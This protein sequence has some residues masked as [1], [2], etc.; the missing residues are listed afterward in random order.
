MGCDIH[1]F[2]EFQENDSGQF[3]SVTEDELFI[4][5]DY[6]LFSAIA[7]GDGGITDDLLYP[8]R[9]LPT[10]YSF[11]VRELFFTTAK[12]FEQI[13][14]GL[15]PEAPDP[16]DVAKSWGEWAVKE[17]QESGNVPEPDTHTPSWL[18]LREIKEALAEAGLEINKQSHEFQE[19]LATMEELAEK[20]SPERVR[21]VFWFDG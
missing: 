10:N 11:A 12:E 16:E 5:R 1:A 19:V 18:N 21:L 8:P 2:I 6:E 9:G 7:F 17:Y 20:Y 14:E 15:G 13:L 4:P 3:Q